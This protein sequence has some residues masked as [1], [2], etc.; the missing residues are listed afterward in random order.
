MQGTGNTAQLEP[1]ELIALGGVFVGWFAM[2]TLVTQL[3]SLQQNLHFYN[4]WTVLRDPARLATGLTGVDRAEA[5]A[6]GVVCVAALFAVL[7]PFRIRHKRAWLAY[8]APLALMMVCAVVL[9]YATSGDL[10]ADNGARGSTGSHVLE[11]ANNLV[12]RAT[13]AFARHISLGFGAYL[14][15]LAS[16]FLAWKGLG[17]YRAA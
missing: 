9:Y 17:R 15:F 2:N 7:I 1:A 6:F 12:N 16:M 5:F 4:V 3:G 14:S 10:L 8:A 13:A 11:F